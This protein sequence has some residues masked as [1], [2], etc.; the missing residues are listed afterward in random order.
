MIL[1]NRDNRGKYLASIMGVK[2]Y[3]QKDPVQ[4][5]LADIKESE[6]LDCMR[7]FMAAV[8][9]KDAPKALDELRNLLAVLEMEEED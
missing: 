3:V 8:A 2:D 1:P 5:P 7:R 4:E 9:D 6:C